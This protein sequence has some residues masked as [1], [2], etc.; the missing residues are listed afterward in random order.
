MYTQF[1][2]CGWC[3]VSQDQKYW[4]GFKLGGGGGYVHAH[5]YH[6]SKKEGGIWILRKFMY[7][8]VFGE[9]S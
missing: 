6:S 3:G 8:H 9:E 4:K 1:K 2:S 7:V 5:V